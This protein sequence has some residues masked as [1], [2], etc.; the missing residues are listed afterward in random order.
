M[1]YFKSSMDRR[2]LESLWNKYWVNTL[3]SSSLLTV[4]KNDSFSVKSSSLKISWNINQ[5]YPHINTYLWLKNI[6]M[7]GW[8]YTGHTIRNKHHPIMTFTAWLFWS[9]LFSVRFFM[10][11]GGGADNT[12]L[13]EFLLC[14]ISGKKRKRSSIGAQLIHGISIIIIIRCQ[15]WNRHWRPCLSKH[16][17]H[18]TTSK[19]LNP[20]FVHLLPSYKD[21]QGMLF[22]VCPYRVCLL[23]F[24]LK[25][26]IPSLYV[27]THVLKIPFVSS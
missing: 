13:V 24:Q 14:D 27:Y 1:S 25:I 12:I 8:W 16:L 11:G 7:T 26:R 6:L 23:L 18:Q 9:L 10:R 21:Y 20:Y 15:I 5:A 2:L 3:S 22:F 4:S 17:C 19:N